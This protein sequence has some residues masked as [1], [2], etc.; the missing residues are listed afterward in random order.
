MRINCGL[1]NYVENIVPTL[2]HN[3]NVTPTSDTQLGTYC[4]QR[5]VFLASCSCCFDVATERPTTIGVFYPSEA[6]ATIAYRKSYF[7]RG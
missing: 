4:N 3:G 1:G 2:G 5:G 7:E 6:N